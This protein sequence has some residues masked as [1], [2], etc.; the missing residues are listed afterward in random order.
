MS[1]PRHATTAGIVRSARLSYNDFPYFLLMVCRERL[2][3]HQ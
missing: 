3:G 2:I 1:S